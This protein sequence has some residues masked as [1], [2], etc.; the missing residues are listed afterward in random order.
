[1]EAECYAVSYAM[2]NVIPF[3]STARAIAAGIGISEHQLATFRTS[4]W[5]DNAGALVL[6]N[7]EPG[8]ILP[9]SKQYAIKYHWFRSHLKPYDIEVKKLDTHAQK[10]DIL[11]RGLKG[12]TFLIIRKLLCGW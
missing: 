3:N 11:T 4:V 2:R 5:E 12:L 6:E 1:M 7:L 10:V 9:S 8:R